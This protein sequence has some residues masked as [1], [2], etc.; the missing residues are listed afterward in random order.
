[1]RLRNK[2]FILLVFVFGFSACKK[3]DDHVK[4]NDQDLT[5]NLLQA[6]SENPALSKFKEYVVLTGVDTLL[7]SSKTFTVWAPSNDALQS[8][9]P[10]IVSDKSLLKAF[11]LNHISNQSYFT[12]NAQQVIRV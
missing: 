7:Q 2:L 1:M 10:S 12:R 3:W 11:V 9:D 5:K 4:V 6:I 8:L